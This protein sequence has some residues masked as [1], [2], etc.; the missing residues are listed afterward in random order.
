MLFFF[1]KKYK[2][3]HKDFFNV[4]KLLEVYF[5]CKHGTLSSLKIAE[6]R[7]DKVSSLVIELDLQHQ[8]GRTERNTQQ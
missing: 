2:N 5:Q 1:F 3:I 8:A 4:K 7:L 6:K